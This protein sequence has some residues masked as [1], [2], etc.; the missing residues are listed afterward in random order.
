MSKILGNISA[1][2][3][4]LM[5]VFL[6][7]VTEPG[8]VATVSALVQAAVTLLNEVHSLPRRSVHSLILLLLRSCLQ[9]QRKPLNYRVPYMSGQIYKSASAYLNFFCL[10][11]LSPM[12]TGEAYTLQELPSTKPVWSS[13]STSTASSSQS[14][15]SRRPPPHSHP[16]P[17]YIGHWGGCL[18]FN[19][20]DMGTFSWKNTS[21]KC[22]VSLV[23]LF[24]A[25]AISP[26]G[27]GHR[28]RGQNH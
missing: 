17:E 7:W 18:T 19:T 9:W 2:C 1:K 8:Y 21:V 6:P 26:W 3:D 25:S 13:A 12:S 14:E 4:L 20:L 28:C 15:T 10:R 11:L 27:A 23:G 16:H 24:I 22:P 5:F